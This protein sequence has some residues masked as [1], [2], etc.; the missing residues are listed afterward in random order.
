MA[1]LLLLMTMIVIIVIIVMI[2][3]IIG[4]IPE[5]RWVVVA[6]AR[7]NSNYDYD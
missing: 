1:L 5:G 4:Q 6:E 7:P 2:M 3:I